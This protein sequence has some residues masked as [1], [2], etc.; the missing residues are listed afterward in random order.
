MK[1]FK[2]VIED[3]LHIN[4]SV[5]FKVGFYIDPKKGRRLDWHPGNV[6]ETNCP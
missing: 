6:E 2:T 5:Y 3:Q 4:I 1:I